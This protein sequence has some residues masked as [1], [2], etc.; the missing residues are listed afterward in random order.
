MYVQYTGADIILQTI[1]ILFFLLLNLQFESNLNLLHA[2]EQ[3]KNN[4]AT[5][6]AALYTQTGRNKNSESTHAPDIPSSTVLYRE[7]K[8]LIFVPES[9][10]KNSIYTT[11]Y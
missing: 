10:K 6:N 9:E 7:H 5:M 3:K 4:H 11:G 1:Y 2:R 8:S